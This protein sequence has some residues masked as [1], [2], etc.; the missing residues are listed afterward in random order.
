MTTLSASILTSRWIKEKITCSGTN[1]YQKPF[2]GES[3]IREMNFID[4]EVF[5][6]GETDNT[7]TTKNKIQEKQTEIKKLISKH[8]PVILRNLDK[9]LFNKIHKNYSLPEEFEGQYTKGKY[10]I[11]DSW[12]MPSVGKKLFGL[13]K[14]IF[15]WSIGSRPVY[16][17]RFRGGYKNCV[18]HVDSGS[19][20]IA[21]FSSHIHL[22]S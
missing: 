9:S 16:L 5:R 8:E 3:K 17:A 14:K 6:N 11:M 1:N 22:F 13:M 19:T 10:L 12:F 21:L 4:C 20:Y 18:A 7:E 2:E 15:P